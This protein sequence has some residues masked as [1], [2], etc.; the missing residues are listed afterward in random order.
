MARCWKQTSKLKEW[1][2]Y[3][4]TAI[5]WII[6]QPTPWKSCSVTFPRRAWLSCCLACDQAVK[7]LC[8]SGFL[9]FSFGQ[10]E[11]AIR[12]QS[13]I[14][15]ASL[16]TSCMTLGNFKFIETLNCSFSIH[17]VGE[18]IRASGVIVRIK[19]MD[20]CKASGKAPVSLCGSDVGSLINCYLPLFLWHSPRA[21][22]VA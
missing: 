9:P 4:D 14:L 12:T 7:F 2:P 15:I 20:A 5:F 16:L 6:R 17:N 3:S 18:I 19:D 1:F 13:S 22:Q 8:N 21:E 11:I 10:L